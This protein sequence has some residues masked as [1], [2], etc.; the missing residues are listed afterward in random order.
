MAG[1]AKTGPQEDR[2]PALYGNRLR[3][4]SNRSFSERPPA[5]EIGDARASTDSD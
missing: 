1:G 5:V 4:K 3:E 2:G